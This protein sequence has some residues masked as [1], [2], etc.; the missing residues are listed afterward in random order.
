MTWS[1]YLMNGW[2]GV[3]SIYKCLSFQIEEL[4]VGIPT[5]VLH[6]INRNHY[7]VVTQLAVVPPNRARTGEEPIWSTA[8]NLKSKYIIIKG[9]WHSST[10]WFFLQILLPLPNLSSLR[11]LLPE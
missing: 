6:F 4:D 7:V 9:D 11:D 5:G 10:N 1:V 3:G 2:M 8:I